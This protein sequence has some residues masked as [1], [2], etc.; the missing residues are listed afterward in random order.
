MGFSRGEYWRGQPLQG[1]LPDSGIKREPTALQADSLP[2]THLGSPR[3][4]YAFCIRESPGLFP[5][6]DSGDKAGAQ[7]RDATM[8]INLK[9]EFGGGEVLVLRVKLHPAVI[10]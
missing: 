9:R 8:G 7:C 2:L 1:N 5:K 3:P 4:V 6:T 10:T